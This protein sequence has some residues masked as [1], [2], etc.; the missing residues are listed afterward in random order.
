MNIKTRIHLCLLLAALICLGQSSIAQI[1]STEV[2][3]MQKPVSKTPLYSLTEFNLAVVIRQQSSNDYLSPYLSL[4]G[5]ISSV[6]G[7]QIAHRL[8]LGVGAGADYTSTLLFFP[9]FADLRLRTTRGKNSPFVGIAGGYAFAVPN[10][11]SYFRD[12]CY[13]GFYFNPMV[14]GRFEL[15]PKTVLHVGIGLRIQ[16]SR[17][18]HDGWNRFGPAYALRFTAVNLRTGLEF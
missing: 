1:V 17:F 3:Q 12:H 18:W 14:G 5:G 4:S 7:M 9:V 6:V 2:S 11:Q 13:G 16:E 10:P 8:H 15:S